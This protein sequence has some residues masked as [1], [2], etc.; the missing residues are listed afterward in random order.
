MAEAET[1]A[2]G[3]ATALGPA[4]PEQHDFYKM[5]AKF[6]HVPVAEEP[7]GWDKQQRFEK[8][9]PRVSL[10]TQVVERI[11]FGSPELDPN[12]LYFGD[13][14]HVMRSLPSES[15]D[16]IY[17]D[18]PFFSQ[19]TYNVL[20]GDQNELRSFKDIW[21]G[22]MNGYLTWL[23][24]RLYE[25]KR[26][27]KKSGL[28][29][30]HLDHHA[31][32]YV[33]VELDR[34]FG[35]EAF[36]NEVIWHYSGWNRRMPGGFSRRHDNLLFVAR[37]T[38]ALRFHSFARAW[39]S[40][41]EYVRVRKQ[42]VR[43][44][45]KGRQYVLSDAGGGKRVKRYLEEAM[46]AGVF[47]DDVW[48]IDKL[49]NSALEA[50]GYPTQKPEV[51]L[52][53]VITAG[54]EEGDV[55]AD[56][57]SGGG[58]TAA[59]AQRLGRRWIAS[60]ISRVAVSITSDRISK[61][62][63]QQQAEATAKNYAISVPDIEIA[64]W[65]IYE[66]TS[67]SKLSPDSFRDFILSAYDARVDSTGGIIHGYKGKEP[68]HVGTPDRDVAIR[69]EDVAEFGNAVLKKLGSGAAGTMIA[70]SFSGQARAM[71]ER[72]AA[73]QKV[74]LTFV[75]LRLIPI[76][77]PDFVAHIAEKDERYK[78][79][80]AFVLPPEVRLR[81]T[82]LDTRKYEFDASETVV[83]NSGA[84]LINAQWDFDYQGFFTSTQGFELQRT[85]KGE[86]ILTAEYT[87]PSAG[88][89]EIA[90]RVQDDLGGEAVYTTSIQVG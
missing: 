38:K 63:E 66:V 5:P 43:K 46:E 35:Y 9:Y 81:R 78:D 73:Q 18:P 83:L 42:K 76:E 11:E 20:F 55:V 30:V 58:T 37:D 19:Q 79:M 48:D 15:I 4:L 3:E 80:V 13:N 32:H 1:Q 82:K 7:L 47:V 49:N 21:E 72:I 33:K 86:P 70:W 24:A 17:I 88:T 64:H 34:L 74:K 14:L 65:G 25:M 60:D 6:G 53:R 84:K 67:L 28:L 90:V 77:S 41:E 31:T 12:R 36:M 23:N 56:F 16:L 44:D 75:K 40:V 85:K 57:F 87:F 2:G 61:V 59:V 39:S 51:L 8:L 71:A 68:V 27:L 10:P 54:S 29:V 50:I 69:K 45:D 26:L 89:H 22:G 62:V 52:E